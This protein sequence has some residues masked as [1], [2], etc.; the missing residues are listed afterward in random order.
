ML[1]SSLFE[2]VR[3]RQGG[4]SADQARVSPALPPIDDRFIQSSAA[5]VLG[6]SVT[7]QQA[8]DRVG[9]HHR[10]VATE[11]GYEERRKWTGQR[12][13]ISVRRQQA[14]IRYKELV[15]RLRNFERYVQPDSFSR[16]EVLKKP[17]TPAVWGKLVV[18]LLGVVAAL[19]G[20]VVTISSF[21]LAQPAWDNP[22]KALTISISFVVLPAFGIAL[23]YKALLDR[24]PIAA[25][26]LR[27]CLA[28]GIS[29]SFVL[30]AGC[31]AYLF[32]ESLSPGSGVDITALLEGSL[33]VGA[34]DEDKLRRWAPV[35][36]TFLLMILDF[37]ATA[38]VKT[39]LTDLFVEFG[40]PRVSRLQEQPEWLKEQAERQTLAA[41][42]ADLS[43][44]E[45]VLNASLED[46]DGQLAA[47]A[48]QLASAA[49]TALAAKLDAV[50][51]L[52]AELPLLYQNQTSEERGRS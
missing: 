13:R 26:R 33:E 39:Y 49:Q 44:E 36:L 8:H 16:R 14:D 30:G 11:Q 6:G 23:W 41:E 9:A 48:H 29:L 37:Q 40:W 25:R 47:R 42:V 15:Q 21:L 50:A 19:L 3:N 32:A 2:L 51:R 22:L 17:W 28:V 20:G 24:S 27:T 18:L 35:L 7:V 4:D 10:Q 46:F 5:A 45:A 31:F 12:A 43:E 34:K 38:F 1:R 52:R